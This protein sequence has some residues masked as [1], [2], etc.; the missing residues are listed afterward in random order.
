MIVRIQRQV[1][2]YALR[3]RSLLA[4]VYAGRVGV[5]EVPPRSS[6]ASSTPSWPT[7]PT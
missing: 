4:D 7:A 2:D 6:P 3:R 5:A 1:V